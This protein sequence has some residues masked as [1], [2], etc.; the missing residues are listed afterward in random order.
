MVLTRSDFEQYRVNEVLARKK[1]T[2]NHVYLAY[3]S[4]CGEQIGHYRN[5]DNEIG[6]ALFSLFHALSSM[7][8]EL[9]DPK[10]PLRPM[11]VMAD[12]SQSTTPDDFSDEQLNF[13]AEIVQDV[14]EVNMRARIAD[15]LWLRKRDHLFAR[16][17]FENYLESVD[18]EHPT[19]YMKEHVIRA[20][21][22][23]TLLN[24]AEL[25]GEAKTLAQQ[26]ANTELESNEIGSWHFM[27]VWLAKYDQPA[28]ENYADQLW[29][30]AEE[31]EHAGD[32]DFAIRLRERAIEIYKESKNPGRKKEAQLELV[33]ILANY[34]AHDA[35]NGDYWV[36]RHRIELALQLHTRASGNKEQREKLQLHQREYAKKSYDNMNW[37]QATA[38]LA[39]ENLDQLN[40]QALQMVESV[41]GKS[42]EDALMTLAYFPHQ[43]S[44]RTARESAERYKQE[45][46]V[47]RIA[48]AVV[49]DP[50]GKIVNRDI[51]FA[52]A[53]YYAVLTRNLFFQFVI[54][55]AILQ[56]TSEHTVD[57]ETLMPI[58]EKSDFIPK[59]RLRTFAY[60]LIAGL[61]FEYVSVAHILPP[62]IENAFRTVLSF[63]GVV[64]S[65][66]NNKMI[67]EE[68]PL[69]W[70]LCHPAI[71]EILG[72][73]LLFDLKTLLVK[74]REDKGLNLRNEM[75]HGLLRDEA[76]FQENEEYSDMHT[77]TM[78]LW[79][80]A[81]SLC[82]LIK[83]VERE[84]E[85][86]QTA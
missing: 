52:T 48:C 6:V 5:I 18:R 78:Y 54:G 11:W 60:A 14:S 12:G 23:A 40:A 4:A 1:N 46:A 13:L 31:V 33:D 37:Q 62:L 38:E 57:I 35:E 61:K 82:F 63:M 29:G 81:L 3:Y 70:I 41:K 36:A 53:S 68:Q 51:P 43:I 45:S 17:A 34:A 47:Y 30:K 83:K 2:L 22:I 75:A 49:F 15:V 76:Y 84:A 59:D 42:L 25:F 50:A 24:S 66:M 19:H 32:L 27:I 21:Q 86:P 67:E 8:M 39:Q 26:I 55:P 79:W 71:K 85:S 65:R 20:M 72:E 10:N 28:R 44:A 56:I 69:G 58:L 16:L 64:T 73:N 77:H 9:V 74:D 7:Y 80:L